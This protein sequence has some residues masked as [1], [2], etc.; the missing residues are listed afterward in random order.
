MTYLRL[1]CQW[2]FSNQGY[3]VS[4]IHDPY[5][6]YVSLMKHQCHLFSRCCQSHCG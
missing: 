1:N 6:L 3:V 4:S 2:T 5:W